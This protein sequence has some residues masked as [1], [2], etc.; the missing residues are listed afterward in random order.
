MRHGVV[1]VVLANDMQAV[2]LYV[3]VRPVVIRDNTRRLVRDKVEHL[4]VVF[5]NGLIVFIKHRDIITR[6][7]YLACGRIL[8]GKVERS[9]LDSV[10]HRFCC[11]CR[12][13]FDVVGPL[14][15]YHDIVAVTRVYMVVVVARHRA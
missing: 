5:I 15:A 13:G 2:V 1:G 8:A 11:G 9:N 7:D 12:A 4:F 10:E 6:S 14:A 3:E